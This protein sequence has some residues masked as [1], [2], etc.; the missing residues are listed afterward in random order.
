MR[1]QAPKVQL[2]LAKWLNF[3]I[4]SRKFLS[5][6]VPTYY[7]V[8]GLDFILSACTFKALSNKGAELKY[9]TI[10]VTKSALCYSTA[11]TTPVYY[12]EGLSSHE[13]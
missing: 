2:G 10:R 7:I 6:T 12:R 13:A 5:V 4:H 8:R 1:F 11:S 9:V 3:N